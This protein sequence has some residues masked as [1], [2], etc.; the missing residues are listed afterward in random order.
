MVEKPW[1]AM[2]EDV[3]I[4]ESRSESTGFLIPS[5]PSLLIVCRTVGRLRLSIETRTAG[6]TANEVNMIR[7][8][9]GALAHIFWDQLG[10]ADAEPRGG[11]GSRSCSLR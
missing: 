5:W 2:T 11:Q 8:A 7:R 3:S 9:P 10:F 6:G 1:R 4:Q